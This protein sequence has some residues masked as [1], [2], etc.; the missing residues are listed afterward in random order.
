MF[1]I[2][3]YG[4]RICNVISCLI[5]AFGSLAFSIA[6]IWRSLDCLCGIGAVLIGLG[7]CGVQLSCIHIGSYFRNRFKLFVFCLFI[8]KIN[9][10]IKSHVLFSLRGRVTS[11]IVGSGQI[12][13]LVFLA[14]RGLSDMG[15]RF[16]SIFLGYAVICGSFACLAF[17]CFPSSSEAAA[18]LEELSEDP[19][20][21][22]A[23]TLSIPDEH[24]TLI[25]RLDAKSCGAIGD[26][27][28]AAE[29]TDHTTLM[30]KARSKYYLFYLFFV[31]T[32]IFWIDFT[33]G[34]IPLL[35]IDTHTVPEGTEVR[36]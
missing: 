25:P 9:G 20:N 8:F 26:L 13:Y 1:V 32:I 27:L 33:A 6:P 36:I 17:L 29:K 21:N 16:S 5:V 28:L 14:M 22:Q 24:E 4:P 3:R 12:S 15:Y 7:G 35:L 11:L 34:A 23:N 10:C 18:A 30:E 31:V 19:L 2:Y